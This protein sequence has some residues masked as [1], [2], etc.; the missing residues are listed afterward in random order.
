MESTNNV[1]YI[2]SHA[3]RSG[4]VLWYIIIRLHCATIT[5]FSYTRIQYQEVQLDVLVSGDHL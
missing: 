1:D 5:F 3:Y 2:M 4:N